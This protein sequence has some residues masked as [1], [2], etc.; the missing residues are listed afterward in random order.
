MK[1]RADMDE[2]DPTCDRTGWAS[3][4]WDAEPDKIQ[5]T[6]RAGYEA[7]IVRNSGGALCGY[8]G[9]PRGH[10]AYE[11]SWDSSDRYECGADGE[12]DYDRE[13][14][15]P[16][17][18]LVVHGGV[19]YAEHCQVDICHVPAPGMPDDVW[20]LGFDCSHCFDIS[21]AREAR[22]TKMGFSPI[23]FERSTYKDVAYVRAE[24]ES[25]AE[26]LKALA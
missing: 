16:I 1:E 11:R 14:E 2:M 12:L 19:N 6:T 10:V 5:W 9:V 3:G 15:N 21:P 7:L 18:G 20:W 24:V 4:P 23:R 25:L 8:V 22:E 13:K 26:Q 17:S